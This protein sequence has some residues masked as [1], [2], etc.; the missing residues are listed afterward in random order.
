MTIEILDKKAN[1]GI[2][3]YNHLN[4]DSIKNETNRFM[5]EWF[6][7][8]TRQDMHTTHKH[9]QMYQLRFFTYYWDTNKP[10][11]YKDINYFKDENSIKELSHIYDWLE[12]EYN[13]K[14]VRSELVNM[15]PNSRIRKHR[16]RSDM[17]F[18]CRRIHIPIKTNKEAI[19]TVNSEIENMAEGYV[20]EI[21]NSKIHS[22]YNNS[23]E[24][25]IHL[26]IDLLPE[27]FANNVFKANDT[28]DVDSH[29]NWNNQSFCVF[30]I[31][32]DYC[33]GPHIEEKN[34]QSFTEYISM[35]K[36]DLANL[37]YE[38][39]NNYAKKNNIDLLDLS[40]MVA[41]SIKERNNVH[42]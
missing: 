13:G 20:Y 41:D 19:F 2:K 33:L 32:S 37:S 17:L 23:S 18:L 21:N 8:T 36:D 15:F 25:R 3:K 7:D 31:T 14:V 11:Y 6:L 29:A 38:N 34:F 12:K 4:I 39:I 42:S 1:W 9:T 10:G 16:D 24:N 5:D 30:C 28:D 27:P 40:K 26:I 35:L 22:V